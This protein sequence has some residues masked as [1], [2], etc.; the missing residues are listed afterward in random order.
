MAVVTNTQSIVR[1]ANTIEIEWLEKFGLWILYIPDEANPTAAL[2]FEAVQYEMSRLGIK[3]VDICLMHGSFD[4]Q[5][6]FAPEHQHN[7]EAFNK[8]VKYFTSVGHIHQNSRKGNII[9]QGSFDR[10]CHG[11]EG[12]KGLHITTVDRRRETWSTEFIEN[13]EAMIFKTIDLSGMELDKALKKCVKLLE[14]IPEG[15]YV[16]Y[17][18][19]S[20]SVLYQSQTVLQNTFAQYQWS[21][22]ATDTV[23]RKHTVMEFT[24]T[25]NAVQL[26]RENLG[27]LLKERVLNKH[28]LVFNDSALTKVINKHL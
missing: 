28:A 7:S 16:R 25:F 21:K 18:A 17:L 27:G 14:G 8:L 6:P 2:T 22:K 24:T 10:I 20:S 11:D 12:V 13:K 19:E 5:M 9:A 26:T 4:Y 23:A 1:L 15:S 3:Q